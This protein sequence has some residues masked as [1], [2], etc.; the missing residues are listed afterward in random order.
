M[1]NIAMHHSILLRPECVTIQECPLPDEF[2]KM[3]ELSDNE[4]GIGMYWYKL[5]K[6]TDN[7]SRKCKPYKIL[8]L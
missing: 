6:D 1:V 3:S 7:P 8:D 5:T 2:F 4:T